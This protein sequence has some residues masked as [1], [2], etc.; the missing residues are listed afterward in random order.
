M[1]LPERLE[2]EMRLGIVCP[3]EHSKQRPHA[4]CH[5]EEVEGRRS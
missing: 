3:T 1:V 4:S 5:R 2:S